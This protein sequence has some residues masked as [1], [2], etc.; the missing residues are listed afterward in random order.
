MEWVCVIVESICVSRLLWRG[1]HVTDS[2]V[3]YWYDLWPSRVHKPGAFSMPTGLFIL[4]EIRPYLLKIIF[5]CSFPQTNLIT[6]LLC[7]SIKAAWFNY[8]S[9]SWKENL[10]HD[11]RAFCSVA[12]CNY[13]QMHPIFRHVFSWVREFFSPNFDNLVILS[14][15]II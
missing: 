5:A 12:C 8:I 3:D 1:R 2:D 4:H 15:C 13:K 6:G 11:S 10:S 14:Y 9:R 7:F